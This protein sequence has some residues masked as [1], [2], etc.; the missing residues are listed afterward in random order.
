M[1]AEDRL[2]FFEEL[3]TLMAD[4]AKAYD[5]LK[6]K[7]HAAEP[8]E[9]LLTTITGTHRDFHRTFLEP[10]PPPSPDENR[11]GKIADGMEI[12]LLVTNS[13]VEE[14][15]NAGK[16]TNKEYEHIL[17]QRTKVQ[18]WIT[19]V[20]AALNAPPVVPAADGGSPTVVDSTLVDTTSGS[21]GDTF[22]L[23]LPSDVEP[24]PE[25]N[26][27]VDVLVSQQEP[28]ALVVKQTKAL[29][30]GIID[31]TITDKSIPALIK[32]WQ[33]VI[34]SFSKQFEGDPIPVPPAIGNLK[35]MTGLVELHS[36]LEILYDQ[37][38]PNVE[39]TDGESLD[40]RILSIY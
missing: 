29:F 33:D 15:A 16:P 5:A 7:Q 25:D 36:L 12:Y 8:I 30:N 35:A 18:D 20:T 19:K 28:N 4:L 32:S 13:D 22:S 9:A 40:S 37:L 23:L 38:L 10:S 17:A 39:Q 1:Q 26:L 24:L 3:R 27:F 6:R 31:P 11:L 2:R 14:L 34:D 21:N